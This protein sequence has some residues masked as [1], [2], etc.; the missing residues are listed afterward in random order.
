MAERIVKIDR[1]EC[2]CTINK[3]I[4]N[5][6]IIYRWD[7]VP[8]LLLGFRLHCVKRLI[9]DSDISIHMP[10]QPWKCQSGVPSICKIGPIGDISHLFS[11]HPILSNFHHNYPSKYRGVAYTMRHYY[12]TLRTTISLIVLLLSSSFLRSTFHIGHHHIV[13]SK[14]CIHPFCSHT[15]HSISFQ[16]LHN[17]SVYLSLLRVLS[18]QWRFRIRI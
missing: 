8:H 15:C 1:I 9:K 17:A 3:Q 12:M 4:P 16:F 2:P 10:T 13:P 18:S 6:I 7:F 5:N 11:C 14:P